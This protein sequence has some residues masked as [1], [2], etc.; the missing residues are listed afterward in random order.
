MRKGTKGSSKNKPNFSSFS[1]IVKDE[2]GHVAKELDTVYEDKEE[3]RGE[4]QGVNDSDIKILIT[5]PLTLT[6]RNQEYMFPEKDLANITR[7][8]DESL[9]NVSDM[10]INVTENPHFLWSKKSSKKK[11]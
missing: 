10:R 8:D 1:S 6:T 2:A 4:V 5:N 3:L 7:T 9:S 11:N